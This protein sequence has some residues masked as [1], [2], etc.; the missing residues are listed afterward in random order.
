MVVLLVRL[1]LPGLLLT[2]ACFLF[3]LDALPLALRRPAALRIEVV[4]RRISGAL[5]AGTAHP[6]PTGTLGVRQS[7]AAVAHG[8]DPA[9]DEPDVMPPAAMIDEMGAAQRAQPLLEGIVG[10]MP[11]G[12]FPAT[13]FGA[14][15]PLGVVGVHLP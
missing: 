8:A 13:G 11:Y 3:F 9:V 14:G 4:L 12:T 2:T 1:P 6:R 7:T 5:A 10:A 15:Q